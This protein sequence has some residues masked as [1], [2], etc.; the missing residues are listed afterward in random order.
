MLR[1]LG[2]THM[3]GRWNSYLKL[4]LQMPRPIQVC[5]DLLCLSSETLVDI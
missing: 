2:D 1:G 3:S 4:V 5:N